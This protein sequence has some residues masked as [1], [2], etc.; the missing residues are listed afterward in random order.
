MNALENFPPFGTKYEWSDGGSVGLDLDDYGIP[1]CADLSQGDWIDGNGVTPWVT[2]T[3]NLLNKP[4]N[5]H[6]NVIMWSWC[7]IDGHNITRYLDNMEILV[8]EYPNVDFV[9]MTGHAQGQGEGGFIYAANQQIRQHCIDNDRILFDFADIESYDPDGTYHYDNPMWD[10][11]D[12]NPGRTNNWGIEWCSANVGSELEQLT[13]GNGVA[14]YGGCGNCAHSGSAGGGE[15]INCVLKGRAVWW[16]MAGLAAEGP[17]ISIAPTSH[18]FGDM[19]EGVTDSTTFEIWNSGTDTLTY[20]LSESCGWIDVNPTS[21]SSSREHDS[22]TVDIDSTGLSEGPYTCNIAISSNGGSDTFSVTVNIIPTTGS[23]SVTSTPS[24]AKVYLDDMYKGKTPHTITNVPAG[25][26]TINLT[27][28]GYLDWSTNVQVRAGETSYVLATLTPIPTT[29]DIRINEIMYNPSTEQD[30]DTDME[31]IELYNNDTETVN[32]SGWTIDD[33]PISNNVMQPWDYVVL[34][35]NKAAFEAYYGALSC[36]V[37]DVTFVLSNNSGDTIVLRNSAGAE[38][39]TV[40]YQASWGAD[41][42]GKTLERKE[43]GGWAES[44]EDGGT[45]CHQNS[46]TPCFIATAAYGT[47]LHEDIDVLRDFRDEYLMTNPAGRT[48]VKVY[49]TTSPPIADVIGA[50]E[51]LRI[52]VRERLVKTLVYVARMLV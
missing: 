40:T 24:D 50:N 18:D 3:R 33:N 1:G 14:G 28:T 20:S 26:H 41:G 45:P 42:N 27:L 11:L 36:S 7:S 17:A 48:F 39:D 19:Y 30:S 6:V 2:A 5:A 12:Y 51:E 23:I 44:L 21:G 49:Y 29:G 31:W 47:P 15:T 13:T 9:F 22:I 43:T 38:I 35:R 25:I 16:M 34:A 46:L 4:E 37:I 32:I 52:I 8:A 10:D